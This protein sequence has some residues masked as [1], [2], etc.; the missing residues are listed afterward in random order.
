MTADRRGAPRYELSLPVQIGDVRAFTR[1][2]GMGGALVVSPRRFTAGDVLDL[3][4]EITFSDPD[5]P[6]RLH[7]TGRVRR[8][9]KVRSQW[10]LAIEFDDLTVLADV[11]A[12]AASSTAQKPATP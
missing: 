2:I 9:H 10:A 3:V 7:C 6:T 5:M 1:N 12:P 4:I 11:I 8:A